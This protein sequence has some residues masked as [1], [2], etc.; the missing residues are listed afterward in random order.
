MNARR[1]CVVSRRASCRTLATCLIIVISCSNADSAVAFAGTSVSAKS[2][3]ASPPNPAETQSDVVVVAQ[4][5]VRGAIDRTS[6]L[7]R[8]NVEARSTNALEVLGRVPSVEVLPSGQ[9]RLLGRSGVTILI[10][11]QEVPNAAGFLRSLQGSQ[12]AQIEVITN[13]SAQFPARGTGGIVNLITRRGG[14]NGLGGSL[15][16]I[17]GNFG[18]YEL[19]ASP[20]WS[21]GRVSLLGNVGISRSG[22]RGDYEEARIGTSITNAAPQR[23]ED[24]RSRRRTKGNSANLV[25]TV[26]ISPKQTLSLNALISGNAG[27]TQRTSAIVEGDLE[28]EQRS[29]GTIGGDVRRIAADFRQEGSR[30]GELTNLSASYVTLSTHS[31]NRFSTA[32]GSAATLSHLSSGNS[33]SEI[34]IKV[35][36][37]LPTGGRRLSIGGPVPPQQPGY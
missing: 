12:V 16:A 33:G 18:S 6:Y 15:T 25:A 4:T 30:P 11:G 35:D 36:H 34:T 7:V 31:D 9:V 23:T 2:K 8:D 21:R 32:A 24:G 28:Q 22:S 29:T 3:A 19:R 17:V 5:R 13:P 1:R 27:W 37:V 20:S 10:D 14:S 26:E